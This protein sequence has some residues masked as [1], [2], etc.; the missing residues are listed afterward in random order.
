MD[1]HKLPS[2]STGSTDR[3]TTEKNRRNQ[4]KSLYAQLSSLVPHYT[5]NADAA[6]LPDKLD[7]A[8]KYIKKLQVSLEKLRLKKEKL[9]GG[10]G[11]RQQTCAD[12]DQFELQIEVHQMGSALEVIMITGLD[13]QF[14]LFSNAVRVIREE[15]AEI[16]NANFYVSSDKVFHIIHSKVE[17]AGAGYGGTSRI[18]ERLCSLVH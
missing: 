13:H 11:S 8:A 1:G 2:C 14:T 7:E 9:Q 3:K 18:Q 16:V 12:D 5:T 15:G 6:S 10:S 17:E 4:M